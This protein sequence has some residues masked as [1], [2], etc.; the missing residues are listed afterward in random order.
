MIFIVAGSRVEYANYVTNNGLILKETRY[1]ATDA[2]FR[3]TRITSDDEVR[4][5][6]NWSKKRDIKTIMR[7]ILL[8][9]LG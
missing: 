1:I 6:G 7:T 9:S 3:G 4:F 8:S 5:I 2:T